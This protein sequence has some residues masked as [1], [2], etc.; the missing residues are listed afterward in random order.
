MET[1][2]I[3]ELK[4]EKYI[5]H[6]QET[7]IY[8][9]KTIDQAKKFGDKLSLKEFCVDNVIIKYDISQIYISK[10]FV[11]KTDSLFNEKIIEFQKTVK[12]GDV[13]SFILGMK[14][15]FGYSGLNHQAEIVLNKN[16]NF[17][18]L[19]NLFLPTFIKSLPF[20]DE[21]EASMGFGLWLQ[22]SKDKNI[23]EIDYDKFRILMIES[24]RLVGVKSNWN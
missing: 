5:G 12:N 1:Y 15:I 22:Y 21:F 20:E 16:N 8:L 19:N 9:T 2:F 24:F 6:T 23:N 7:G 10:D 17:F 18:N 11:E 4:D 14:A 3:I 13:E